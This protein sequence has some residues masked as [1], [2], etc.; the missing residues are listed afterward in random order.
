MGSNGVETATVIRTIDADVALIFTTTS[1]DYALEGYRLGAIRYLEKPVT[2]QAVLEALDLMMT[3]RRLSSLKLLI[4]GK[5]CEFAFK[6]ILF[7]EQCNYDIL[8]HTVTGKLRLS[9]SV[10]L[11]TLEPS[12]PSFFL[13]CHHSFIVNLHH[14]R[15]LDQKLKVFIMQGGTR[16]YIRHRDFKAVEAAFANHLFALTRASL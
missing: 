9:R 14:V 12:L 6:E 16:V 5:P 7:F 3:S 10:K 2:A 4:E 15:S 13:R 11:T 8:V 1:P